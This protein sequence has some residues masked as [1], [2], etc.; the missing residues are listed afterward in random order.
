MATSRR[1]RRGFA[2]LLVAPE[3]RGRHEG[4][5]AQLAPVLLVPLVDH[6]HV[7]VQGVL[8]LE[9]GVAVMALERPLAL[10]N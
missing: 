4:L 3:H 2:H 1:S 5:A 9:G 8:P 10:E 6:L 7:D